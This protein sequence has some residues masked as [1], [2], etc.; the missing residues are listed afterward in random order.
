MEGKYLYK[1]VTCWANWWRAESFS[2]ISSYTLRCK[3]VTFILQ[4]LLLDGFDEESHNKEKSMWQGNE[5]P[6]HSTVGSAE[7][8]SPTACK[9]LKA[10]N[11]DVNLEEDAS[12]VE[13]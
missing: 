1:F 5:D 9:E 2:C 7:A 6:L 4:S 11:N 3:V 10:D 12:P 13:P 8:L